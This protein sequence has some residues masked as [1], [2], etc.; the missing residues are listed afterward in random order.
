MTFG[1]QKRL[2]VGLLAFVAPIPLPFNEV[3][4]WG[5]VAPYLAAVAWFLV[6]ARRDPPRWLPAWALNVLGLVYLPIFLLDLAVWHRG[7]VVQPVIHLCLF[8]LVAKLFAMV[9]ERD[10]WQ[11][12]IG[13]FFL[14]LAAMGTS[15]HPSIVLYLVTFLALSV[16]LLAR[17][18]FFHVLADFAHEA[19]APQVPLRGLLT[20]AILGTMALAV[21]LFVALPRLS[22]PY[23]VG[24]GGGGGAV[25]E[26][27]GFSDAVT[28]NSI[29][30]IRANNTVAL[31]VQ[32]E[33]K[34]VDVADLRLKAATYDLY[35]GAS[36]R[37]SPARALMNH[38]QGVRFELAPRAPGAVHW[39]KLWLPPLHSRSLPLPV[40]ARTV[41]PHS[42]TLE[43]DEG[44]AISF[45]VVP[46]E[47]RDYRVA[48]GGGPVL[49]G[50][51]PGPA[52]DPTLDLSGV[53]PRIAKLAARVTGEGSPAE[54]A[55]RLETHLSDSYGY[56][57]D[58]AGRATDNPIEDFLFRY[59]SGQC[60]YFSSAMVLMLRSQGIPA[61]LVTGFLGAEYNPFEG[62][63]IVRNGNAHAWVEAYMGQ[64]KGWRIFDP[65]PPAG[66]PLPSH[67][68]LPLLARQA[69]DYVVFRWD[70]YVLT[71]GIYDQLQ[72]FS[73]V[74]GLWDRFASLFGHHPESGTAASA[75]AA[76][77]AGT[78]LAVGFSGVG[79]PALGCVLAGCLL[80]AAAGGLLAWRL[81]PPLTATKAYQRI[82][83]ELGRAGMPLPSSAPPLAVRRQATTRFP[84]AAH[85]TGRVIDFYL[86]E[87]FGG[88]PLAPT[89]RGA[90]KSALAEARQEMRR[91]G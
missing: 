60:E 26:A 79:R 28:L 11:A 36:W 15:V 64:G 89:D 9:R 40:E 30:Q 18:A 76:P 25:L 39:L 48:V 47:T 41:E 19:Q 22:S 87:S 35:Q 27:A 20:A 10:K 17:F 52:P 5:T 80:L 73:Q 38:E 33:D 16:V 7:H 8:V 23:I 59:H 12:V 91:A 67:E 6:R 42:P 58:F 62:Y 85:A 56:T 71:Y 78:A 75:G 90:L 54:R 81:R 50:L 31:R 55:R 32:D 82:R 46:L 72:V 84:T 51:V 57:L 3:V 44:G 29:G 77:A 66:R 2:L 83:R 4:G 45:P 21:P 68:G 1:R 49:L 88:H 70:R 14:F 53:T 43:I 37:R 86:R 74:R 13:V 34:E 65:T 61:R 69:W 63:Y 24:R